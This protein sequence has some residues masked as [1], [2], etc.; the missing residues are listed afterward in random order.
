MA[1]LKGQEIFAAGVWNGLTFNERDLD[2][3]VE[4]FQTLDELHHVPLKLGHNEEQPV[5]DGQPA[6][7]WVS[8]VYRRGKKLLADFVDVPSVVVQAISKRLYRKVSI[9]LLFNVTHQDRRFPLVLDAV[10]LLGADHPAVNTLDDLKALTMVRA[11]LDVEGRVAWFSAVAGNRNDNEDFEMDK[12]DIRKAVEEAVAPF[13]AQLDTQ[14]EELKKF[15]A[16]NEEL[17]EENKTLKTAKEKQEKDDADK[18]V[19]LARKDVTGLFDAAV[20][21]KKISPAQREVYERQLG[22]KDDK[23]VVDIDTEDLR[24]MLDL[25]EKKGDEGTSQAFNRQPGENDVDANLAP[26]RLVLKR[27]NEKVAAYVGSPKLSFDRAV[28]Q[29]LEEDPALAKRYANMQFEER[30]DNE[31]A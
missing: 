24:K 9:E 20:K 23:R 12:D 8:R 28:E 16:R 13:K 30:S 7:G 31:A 22:V 4:T 18:K 1:D 2:T 27:A 3:I 6:L 29:V 25:P 14:A 5:T 10:A 21:A 17:E 26:D 11:D 15:K 19:E